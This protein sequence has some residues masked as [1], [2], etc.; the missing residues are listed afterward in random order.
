MRVGIIVQ[1]GNIDKRHAR[2]NNRL[3]FRN[4]GKRIKPRVRHRNL[5]DV[6]LDRTERKV[7]RLRR[8]GPRQRI[9]QCRLANVWQ[10]HNSHLKAHLAL[11]LPV[12]GEASTA[13]PPKVQAPPP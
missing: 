12:L 6:R 1:T 10:P 9:E 4:L 11:S 3:R 13:R 7:R 5:A 2:R 8:R